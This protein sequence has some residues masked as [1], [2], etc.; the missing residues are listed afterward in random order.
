MARHVLSFTNGFPQHL[1][2]SS[3]PGTM[4]GSYSVTDYV[5]YAALDMS[6]TI[7]ASLYF[8]YWSPSSPSPKAPPV[9]QPSVCSLSVCFCFVSFVLFD[10]MY[11]RNHMVFVFFRLISVR[12]IPSSSTH[13]LANDKIS[14]FFRGE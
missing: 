14:F 13:V 2:V 6:V 9:W 11:K 12:I 7:T 8:S 1:S 5:L 3:P 4:R 10:S